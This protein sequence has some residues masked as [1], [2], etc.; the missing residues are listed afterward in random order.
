MK[1]RERTLEAD[2]KQGL[3]V[4]LAVVVV[5]GVAGVA[6]A[7]DTLSRPDWS[8]IFS[9]DGKVVDLKGGLDAFFL[10]DK[11]SDGVGLDMS[12]IAPAEKPTV[13]NALVDAANDLANGYVYAAKDPSGDLQIYAGVERFDSTTDTY[14]EFEFYQDLVQVQGGAPWLIHG[15]RKQNDALVR[16]NFVGGQLSSATFKRWDGSAYQTVATVAAD[17]GSECSGTDY[18]VC[19]GQPPVPPISDEAWDA[20]GTAVTVPEPNA[21]VEIGFNVSVLLG[22]QV[23]FTSLQV[24]T[25]QDIILDGFRRLGHWAQGAKRGGRR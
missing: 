19:S 16:V 15:D 12:A 13:D 7:Q 11:V 17:G 25:P 14:V 23:E 18:L 21:F 1:A 24:R 3:L 10:E 20:A 5:S 4:I 22:S 2:M 8:A 6:A 9:P